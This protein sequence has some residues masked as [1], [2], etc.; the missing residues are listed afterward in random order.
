[1]RILYVFPHPD[2]ESFGPAVGIAAQVRQGHDVFLLTLT[3]GGATKARHALGLSVEQMGELRHKEMLDVEKVL[4]LAGMTVLDLPDSG[5]KELD[6]RQIERPI[7]GHIKK[8]RPDVV[9]TYAVH[10]ISGFHDHLVGHA[11]VKR[12][13]SELKEEGEVPLKRM[14]FYTIPEKA[15]EKASANGWHHLN[16]S[17]EDEIDCVIE[18]AEEDRERALSALDC[19]VSY[20][21]TIQKSG[22]RDMLGTNAA[23]EFYRENF[24]PPIADMC[25]GLPA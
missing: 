10:G 4:G 16:G 19:Y 18:A 9:V 5:L 17:K 6:P 14:A 13:F 3:K 11:A 12:V 1:M 23:F 22:I 15:A 25:E 24:T 8:I 7:A 2:D 21:E 20:Q